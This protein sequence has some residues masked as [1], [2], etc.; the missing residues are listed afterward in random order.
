MN[1]P[2]TLTAADVVHRPERACFELFVD[3]QRCRA[4]YRLAGRTMVVHHTEVPPA[5]EGQGLA[6]IVVRAVFDHAAAHGLS[7]EPRCSYV[8]VWARRHPEVGPLLA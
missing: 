5:L 2:R 4:D 8:R 7:I 6:A 1:T 3:G